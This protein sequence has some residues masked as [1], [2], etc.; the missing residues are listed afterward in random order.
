MI[1]LL[2]SIGLKRHDETSALGS[3]LNVCYLSGKRV[4]YVTFG[5]NVPD[6]IEIIKPDKI[7]KA[8]LGLG[9]GAGQPFKPSPSRGRTAVT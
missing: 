1:F 6:D 5:Q 8:L 7:A 4:S 3:I 2:F 9:Q